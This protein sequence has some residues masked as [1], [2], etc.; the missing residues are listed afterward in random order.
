MSGK[1]RHRGL[2]AFLALVGGADAGLDVGDVDLALVVDLLG[3]RQAGEEAAQHVVGGDVG[4]REVARAGAVLVLAVVDEGVDGDHRDAGVDRLLQRCD[5]LL[6]VGGRDQDRVG[7]A[8]DHRLQHRHL[9]GRV[10]LR[11]ALEQQL[12]ADRLGRHLGTLA[13]GDVEGVGGE[14]GDQCDGARVLGGGGCGLAEQ[15]HDEGGR[16]QER[17]ERTLHRMLSL[18]GPDRSRRA[19]RGRTLVPGPAERQ[20]PPRAR[21]ALRD[22]RVTWTRFQRL[23]APA[24][25]R[26]AAGGDTQRLGQQRQ[27]RRV[28]TAA[29]GRCRHLDREPGGSR[30]IQRHALDGVAPRSRRDLDRQLDAVRLRHHGRCRSAWQR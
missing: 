14:P 26:H 22:R 27:H 18:I 7:L 20:A 4:E 15:A 19:F 28:G 5:Q 1:L 13:H 23:A 2:E 21:R 25:S 11:R 6:L 3:Q 8:R 17:G 16:A 24:T 29:I 12:A 10:E 30:G 9:Q